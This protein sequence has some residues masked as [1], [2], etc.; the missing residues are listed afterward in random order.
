MIV[1]R[2]S[3]VRRSIDW[4]IDRSI[5]WLIDRSI[6]RL[7]DWSIDRSIDWSIDRA[8]FGIVRISNFN[9]AK[10]G[11]TAVGPEPYR[12]AEPGPSLGKIK[13]CKTTNERT[14]ERRTNERTTNERTNDEKSFRQFPPHLHYSAEL[15]SHSQVFRSLINSKIS[16]KLTS[17]GHTDLRSCVSG[18][19]FVKESDFDVKSRLAPPK[20]TEFDEKLKKLVN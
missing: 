5:D 6:D 9:F 7:I 15:I 20:S 12:R 3:F 1:R 18:A 17:K 11:A 4:S 8:G 2:R 13:I 19:K 10:A 16:R 14:N